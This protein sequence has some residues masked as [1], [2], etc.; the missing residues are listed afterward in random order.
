MRALWRRV[1]TYWFAA[2]LVPLLL[3]VGLSFTSLAITAS[4][5]LLG[6]IPGGVGLLF[7]ALGFILLAAA[8]TALYRLVP[9][10]HVRS[11]PRAGRRPV[12]GDRF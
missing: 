12:R 1:L 4:R 9:N 5:G 3:G 8:M 11:A 7:D 6:G 10:T 2:T